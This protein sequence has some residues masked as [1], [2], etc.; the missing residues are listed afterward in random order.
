M[1][2]DIK[3]LEEIFL[4]NN[5]IKFFWTSIATVLTAFILHAVLVPNTQADDINSDIPVTWEQTKEAIVANIAHKEI[6]WPKYTIRLGL[7]WSRKT[8][9]TID[10]KSQDDR[11]RQ[12][13]DKVGLGHTLPTWKKLWDDYKLDYTLPLCIAWADSHL[14][15]ANKSSNNIGNVGNNDR[16]DVVHYATLD[17]GIEAIFRAL[18]NKWMWGSTII[19]QL[20]GEW[21]QR[22]W[23]EWCAWSKVNQKC[24]ASSLGV[25]SSN[26][27]NCMSVIK[28]HQVTEKD[29]FR[30]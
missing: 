6:K 26:V 3:T 13:L 20:S 27:T 1:H 29:T 8:I 5:M 11:A 2:L 9:P 15:K 25:W 14:G 17:K 28:N 18:N 21:R 16:G 4:N 12:W 24:Y 19:W 10:G 22:M 7:Q 30:L 23:I